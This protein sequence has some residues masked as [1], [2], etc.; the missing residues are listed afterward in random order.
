MNINIPTNAYWEPNADAWIVSTE[1]EYYEYRY[2]Y[3]IGRAH[4]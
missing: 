4:V 2:F 1:D 3:K